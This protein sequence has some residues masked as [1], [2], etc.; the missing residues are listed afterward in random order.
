LAMRAGLA[1]LARA[2]LLDAADAAGEPERRGDA[3]DG[4]RAA[5]A[6]AEEVVRLRGF[7]ADRDPSVR[8]AAARS[9]GG[10]DVQLRASVG[11]AL[12]RALERETDP[13]AARA[14]L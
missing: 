12:E 6:L 2:A 5:G 3:L 8:A 14:L 13:D 7:L 1:A 9:L 4:V 10:S 11:V